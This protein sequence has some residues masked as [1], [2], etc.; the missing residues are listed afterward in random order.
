MMGPAGTNA[1][2]KLAYAFAIAGIFPGHAPSSVEHGVVDRIQSQAQSSEGVIGES[3]AAA[4]MDKTDWSGNVVG[5]V[6]ERG[7]RL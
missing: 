2:L 3:G 1:R 6:Y 7:I 4:I 5:I